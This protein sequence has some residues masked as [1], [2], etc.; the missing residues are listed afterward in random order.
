MPVNH[1]LL[2]ETQPNGGGLSARLKDDGSEVRSPW[3]ARGVVE[4]CPRQLVDFPVTTCAWRPV[5]PDAA[6]YAASANPYDLVTNS[7]SAS[8]SVG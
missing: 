5:S 4:R 8:L 6:S 2:Y 3:V 7:V 1:D